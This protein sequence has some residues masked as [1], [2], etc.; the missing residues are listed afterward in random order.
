MKIKVTRI[1]LATLSISAIVFGCTKSEPLQPLM[2]LNTTTQSKAEKPEDKFSMITPSFM[3]L[4]KGQMF[5]FNARIQLN[6]GSYSKNIM[7]NSTN[8]YAV[9]AS[10]CGW[11]NPMNEGFATITATA[12]ED[13]TKRATA[14]VNV[15]KYKE[16]AKK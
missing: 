5:K 12:R 15:V 9:I 11:V 8:P 16:T 1:L 6:D 4:T 14:T 7:W 13:F 2:D 3:T 10:F